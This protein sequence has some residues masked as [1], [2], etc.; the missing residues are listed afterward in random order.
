[1]NGQEENKGKNSRQPKRQSVLR[2]AAKKKSDSQDESNTNGSRG[3]QKGP[4]RRTKGKGKR[5][6]LKG[7]GKRP[8]RKGKEPA[9]RSTMGNGNA[10]AGVNNADYDANGNSGSNRNTYQTSADITA[11]RMSRSQGMRAAYADVLARLI[12]KQIRRD[13]DLDNNGGWRVDIGEGVPPI[14]IPN[15]K[16]LG[17]SRQ[18]EL[19]PALLAVLLRDDHNAENAVIASVLGQGEIWRIVWSTEYNIKP[20]A[21]SKPG[22]VYT[23]TSA[24]KKAQLGMTFARVTVTPIREHFTVDSA[25]TAT[26]MIGKLKIQRVNTDLLTRCGENIL[27]LLSNNETFMDS[28]SPVERLE[29]PEVGGIKSLLLPSTRSTETPLVL[30]RGVDSDNRESGYRENGIS[31]NQNNRVANHLLRRHLF[32]RQGGGPLDEVFSFINGVGDSSETPPRY[33]ITATTRPDGNDSTFCHLIMSSAT[34]AIPICGSK[35]FSKYLKDSKNRVVHL[36]GKIIDEVPLHAWGSSVQNGR[37]DKLLNDLM[38]GHAGRLEFYTSFNQLAEIIEMSINLGRLSPESVTTAEGVIKG[39]NDELREFRKELFRVCLKL[40]L[41]TVFLLSSYECRKKVGRRMHPENRAPAGRPIHNT[42]RNLGE[43]TFP[44]AMTKE[45]Y[46]ER[47]IKLLESVEESNRH[48]VESRPGRILEKLTELAM[49]RV[50]Q[51]DSESREALLRCN[52]IIERVG[53]GA[54]EPS[55]NEFNNAIQSLGDRFHEILGELLN[56]DKNEETVD[57][58]LVQGLEKIVQESAAAE[59]EAAAAD[60]SNHDWFRGLFDSDI[61]GGLLN[62]VQNNRPRVALAGLHS[63]NNMRANCWGAACPSRENEQTRGEAALGLLGFRAQPYLT[64]TQLGNT[65]RLVQNSASSEGRLKAFEDAL[66]GL[67]PENSEKAQSIF[68]SS[69]LSSNRSLARSMNAHPL[70]NVSPI[71][72]SPLDAPSRL[73]PMEGESIA[74]QPSGIRYTM[75]HGWREYITPWEENGKLYAVLQNSSGVTK[76]YSITDGVFRGW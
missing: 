10:G 27:S 7:K 13:N 5:P 31:E 14:K 52:E 49:K 45:Q 73:L 65:E 47:I 2:A 51:E 17:R 62:N 67:R 41:S 30:G 29:I 48:A 56:S 46:V 53:T 44:R 38:F 9:R 22:R 74:T 50:L 1:M 18:I 55:D 21:N 11:Q 54:A 33:E 34:L 24:M 3:S 28:G 57:T 36:F 69:I 60:D 16:I 37:T 39:V 25:L 6:S 19:N 26:G 75:P 4:R 15:I 12:P 23:S 43:A 58:F 64:G 32:R 40:K 20:R 61:E 68:A 76:T 42:V 70:V 35:L 8:S 59:A 72:T 66:R 71:R 63:S